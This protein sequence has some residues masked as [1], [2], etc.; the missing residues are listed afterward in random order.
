MNETNEAKTIAK[1]SEYAN[2]IQVRFSLHA[3]DFFQFSIYGQYITLYFTARN[4]IELTY[5]LD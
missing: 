1:I 5:S 3:T 4:E 2:A